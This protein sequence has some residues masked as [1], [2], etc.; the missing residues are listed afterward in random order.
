MTTTTTT[1]TITRPATLGQH[2]SPLLSAQADAESR[3]IRFGMSIL[4]SEDRLAQ[5]DFKHIIPALAR[6]AGGTPDAWE[7]ACWTCLSSTSL[8]CGDFTDY[9]HNVEENFWANFGLVAEN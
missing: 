3:G 8:A 2:N 9:L 7:T 6:S 5:P 1:I 4:A